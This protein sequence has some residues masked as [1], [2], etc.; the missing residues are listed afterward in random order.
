M[1]VWPVRRGG[2][3]ARVGACVYGTWAI[4]SELAPGEVKEIGVP[5]SVVGHGGDAE[6]LRWGVLL[7]ENRGK[8]DSVVRV[9]RSIKAGR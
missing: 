9:R 3:G 6:R 7:P 2:G 1:V 4:H 5:M 8:A